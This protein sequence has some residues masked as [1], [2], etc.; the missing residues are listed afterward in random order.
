M[1]KSVVAMASVL[2]LG[3]F[4]AGFA[5]SQSFAAEVQDRLG[6]GPKQGITPIGELAVDEDLTREE[7][8]EKVV[9]ERTRVMEE[10]VKAGEVS[11]EQWEVCQERMSERITE[12]LERQGE[13]F[14]GQ[15]RCQGARQGEGMGRGAQMRGNIL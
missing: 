15:G 6:F 4:V 5:P 8:I 2:I 14:R 1:K 9:E 13:C 12:R 3:L 11:E 10:R 7:L